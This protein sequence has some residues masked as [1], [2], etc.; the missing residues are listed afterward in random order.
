MRSL[1]VLVIVMILGCMQ[2]FP[3]DTSDWSG[4]EHFNSI[5]QVGKDVEITA[6]LSRSSIYATLSTKL[7]NKKDIL[8]GLLPSTVIN[9]SLPVSPFFYVNMGFICAVSINLFPRKYQSNY[10]S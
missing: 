2:I 4:A 7:K 1:S 8:S 5:E 6:S 10:L 3:L 9:I